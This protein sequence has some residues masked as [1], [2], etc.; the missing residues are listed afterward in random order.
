MRCPTPDELP[1][2]PEGKTGWPW[3]ERTGAPGK[4]PLPAADWP[5]ISIVTPS[6][7]RAEYI[8]ETIRSVLL[9]GYPNLEYLIIDGGSTD[10]TVDVIRKYEPW[11]AHW[12]SEPDECQSEAIN[13]GLQRATGQV[14][15]YINT[16]DVYT[17]GALQHVGSAFADG[18]VNWLSG[19]ARL[20]GPGVG[21]GYTWPRR[22]WR[23]RWEWFVRNRLCQPS[24][25]WR[26]R[27]TDD[28]GLFATDLRISMDYD[29]WLRMV[30]AG[31]SLTWTETVLSRFRVHPGSITGAW[32]GGFAT[33]DEIVRARHE[34]AL[35]E[36]ERRM[37]ERARKQV[38][39]RRF[40]WRAWRRAWGGQWRESLQDFG[41]TVRACPRMLLNPKTWAVPVLALGAALM[42]PFRPAEADDG[43]QSNTTGGP[44]PS[45]SS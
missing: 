16:D 6:Y 29:Y 11:L 5:R 17:P 27:V 4:A 18:D 41:R 14:L 39:A 44:Q 2:P 8:E 15:A 32:S 22:P 42:S 20:F 36:P 19:P 23:K 3:T 21:P 37:A 25:F 9:Q 1:A 34:E 13:K 33:E 31:Y 24:T 12:V 7:N 35:T 45:G 30:V 10:G 43:D 38:R 26:R 40:R 28:I